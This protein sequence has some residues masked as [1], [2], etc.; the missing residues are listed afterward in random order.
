MN[1]INSSNKKTFLFFFHQINPICATLN[2]IHLTFSLSPF[3]LPL[4]MASLKIAC[5]IFRE[6]PGRLLIPLIA[7][8]S[9][10]DTLAYHDIFI[11]DFYP[12][13]R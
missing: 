4:S 9:H 7:I 11:K 12:I 13:E 1:N 8:L 3:L 10:K 2:H 6:T 5:Y